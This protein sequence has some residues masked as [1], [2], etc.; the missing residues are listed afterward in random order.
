M[1]NAGVMGQCGFIK[2]MAKRVTTEDFVVRA[3]EVHGDRYD[4]TEAVYTRAKDKITIICGEHG[5]FFQ[6]ISNH[7]SNKRG[8]PACGGSQSLNLETFVSRAKAKHG[9]R[10]DYSQVNY[11]NSKT[12]VEIICKLH[13]SFSASPGNHMRLASGCPRCSG[14]GKTNKEFADE[15][16]GIHGDRYDYHNVQYLN[17]TTKIA[18]TCREHGDFQQ[19]PNS[20]LGGVGCAHCGGS[21]R[22]TADIFV[23]RALQAHGDRYDY[24]QVVYINNRERVTILCAAHGGFTQSPNKHMAG[25]GCPTCAVNI[26]VDARRVPEVEFLERAREVHGDTYD[27]SQIEYKDAKTLIVIRCLKHGLFLQEPTSHMSGTGCAKC[28]GVAK[29]T[30]AEFIEE[31][32]VVHG[33]KYDYSVTVYERALTNLIIC[34]PDHGEF[35]QI[36]VSHLRGS[37]CPSCASPGFDPGKPGMVYY[38]RITRSGQKPLYKIGITNRSVEIRFPYPEDRKLISV[39]KEWHFDKGRDAFEMEAKIIRE[40]SNYSYFGEPVI[41]TGNTELFVTDIL[42]LDGGS[43]PPP[44]T[45][46]DGKPLV[47]FSKSTEQYVAQAR[48]CH[49]DKY[50]YSKVVYRGWREKVAILCSEHGNFWQSPSNHLFG[51]GCPACAG[52]VRLTTQEFIKRAKLVHGD[53]FDYSLVEYVNARTKVRIICPEHGPF[54]QQPSGH[55]QSSG[56]GPCR[57]RKIS[58]SKRRTKNSET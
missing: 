9:D 37:G 31:A 35:S 51:D 10:Y 1:D 33:N 36:A 57:G 24:S 44:L 13:G 5:P 55:L 25:R 18:I 50:D 54:E 39:L 29:K 19:T 4:Y 49:K 46:H 53:R 21:I 7:I 45:P 30:T 27:Y 38:L 16:R 14:R 17:A 6:V 32:K 3:Q 47:K 48:E 43:K 34:C 8:C 2:N 15:A 58:E 40:H 52:N 20:H 26:R 41:H 56:C 28:A 11:V 42:G 22:L 23:E 12:D